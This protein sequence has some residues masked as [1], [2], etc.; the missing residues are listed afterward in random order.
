MRQPMRG[1]ST[2]VHVALHAPGLI[3]TRIHCSTCDPFVRSVLYCAH[4]GR[5]D[6]SVRDRATVVTPDAQQPHAVVRQRGHPPHR[7]P[8]RMIRRPGQP[9]GEPAGGLRHQGGG[10]PFAGTAI[11]RPLPCERS[12]QAADIMMARARRAHPRPNPRP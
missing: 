4:A 9:V 7:D 10:D 5:R 2:S 8:G 11:T 6:V 3:A 12:A 1:A